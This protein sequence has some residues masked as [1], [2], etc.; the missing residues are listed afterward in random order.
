MKFETKLNS[1]LEILNTPLQVMIDDVIIER[2]HEYT[3]LG[4][5]LDH[6]ICWNLHIKYAR[7]KLA[8]STPVLGK[9]RNVIDH[10]ALYTL[11]CSHDLLYLKYCVEVWG[12]TYKAPYSHYEY[13]K[14]RA[15]RTEHN[16]GYWET[17]TACF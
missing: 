1:C 13:Y 2:V 9:T 12:S 16:G 4:V 7:A 10:K 6:K 15:T 17:L 14:K 5:M 11:Y 3:F 8:R